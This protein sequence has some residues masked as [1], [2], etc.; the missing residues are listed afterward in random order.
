MPDT[1]PLIDTCPTCGRP[2]QGAHFPALDAQSA[3]ALFGKSERTWRSWDSAGLIP[4]PIRVG[5][6]TFW[7]PAEIEA[8]FDAGCPARKV[9]ETIHED[10]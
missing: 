9:W 3:A 6:S 2:K 4:A 5:R 7:K 8:W 1:L 10:A